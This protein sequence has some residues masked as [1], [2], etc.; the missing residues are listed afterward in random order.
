M[1]TLRDPSTLRAEPGVEYTEA[2][3]TDGADAFEYFDEVEGLVAVGV[4]NEAGA[5]LLMD[6]PH[7]WRLP[8]GH[9]PGGADWLERAAE[10]AATLTGAE[11]AANEVLRVS[12]VTH[13]LRS[14]TERTATSY[15]LVAGTEP[16][17]GEPVAADPTFGEWSDLDLAWF[18]E[19]PDDAYHAHGDAV[20]DIEYFLDAAE[21]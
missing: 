3:T 16:V 7:G 6:S 12:A 9:V 17:A 10:I 8:Y 19:V 20:D 21:D 14:D 1:D 2:R 13:E 4:T 18:D 15:D 5:V 11:P